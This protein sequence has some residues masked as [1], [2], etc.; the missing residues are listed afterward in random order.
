V[1]NHPFF[2]EKYLD[3][4]INLRKHCT[5]EQINE[6]KQAKEGPQVI[7]GKE[8]SLEIKIIL[9]YLEN[10]FCQR[11][12]PILLGLETLPCQRWEQALPEVGTLR[13]KL[14]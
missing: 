4:R 14:T 2:G 7:S 5:K 11:W 10:R 12:E 6:R 9:S 8:I 1:R 3:R 13:I